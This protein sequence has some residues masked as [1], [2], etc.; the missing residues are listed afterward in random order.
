[1]QIFKESYHFIILSVKGNKTVKRRVK[2]IVYARVII[3]ISNLGAK[4][5]FNINI[6]NYKIVF[7]LLHQK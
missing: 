7:S 4:I 3:Y 5:M 6:Y 1:M 2:N